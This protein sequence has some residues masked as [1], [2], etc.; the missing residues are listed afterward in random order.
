MI[1]IIGGETR[2]FR[3][4]VDLYYEAGKKAGH[5]REHLKVGVH[6]IGYVAGTTEEAIGDFYPGYAQTMNSFG[7]ERGFPNFDRARFD[8]YRNQ[9]GS[10]LVGSPGEIVQKI[11]HQSEELG[12]ISRLTFQM[13]VAGAEMPPEKILAS[14]ELIGRE[15]VPALKSVRAG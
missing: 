9:E 15:V 8:L 2:R 5:P 6:A 10:L 4:L 13:D 7:K 11:R 14:I 1:A 3:P 12:G